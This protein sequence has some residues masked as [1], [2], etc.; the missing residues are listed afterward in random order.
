M[1][2]DINNLPPRS[3]TPLPADYFARG[4]MDLYALYSA[5]LTAKSAST[6]I[7]GPETFAALSPA[8][9]VIPQSQPNPASPALSQAFVGPSPVSP[10]AS[11]VAQTQARIRDMLVDNSAALAAA[12]NQVGGQGAR[13]ANDHSDAVE[14]LPMGTT[15]NM[16][17]ERYP[18]VRRRS[19]RA[20]GSARVAGPPWG[21]SP[22]PSSAG[23]ECPVAG[24]LDTGLS[25]LAKLFLFTGVAI[26]GLAVLGDQR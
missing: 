25:G 9:S 18:G 21:G 24:A 12:V 14:V 26:I 20:Q 4:R 6:C 10:L 7:P 23:G 11:Q 1:L 2:T 19:T 16:H 15:A 13:S 17:A 5:G 22:I 3:T 8:G